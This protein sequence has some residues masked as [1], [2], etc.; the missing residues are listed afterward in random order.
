[1]FGFYYPRDQHNVY[2]Q[3]S[4]FSSTYTPVTVQESSF[5]HL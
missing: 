2:V 1:M 4:K 5:C 3:I